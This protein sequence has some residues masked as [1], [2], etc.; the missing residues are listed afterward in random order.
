[1]E[2]H[3]Y[4]NTV[5][6]LVRPKDIMEYARGKTTSKTTLRTSLVLIL[7][8]D[9]PHSIKVLGKIIDPIIVLKDQLMKI[10]SFFN[11][12]THKE[13]SLNMN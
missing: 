7:F 10:S 11:T 2:F 12:H 4:V 3:S 13:I 1:M 9:S 8:E 5:I 6:A